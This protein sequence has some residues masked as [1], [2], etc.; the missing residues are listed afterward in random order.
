[1]LRNGRFFS[2]FILSFFVLLLVFNVFLTLLRHLQN[3][4]LYQSK[5]LFLPLK[6]LL[7]SFLF[8]QFTY[9]LLFF[10]SFLGRPS[11]FFFLLSS[12]LPFRCPYLSCQ[13]PLR[14]CHPS[15]LFSFFVSGWL[16]I[17]Y[18]LY[19]FSFPLSFASF[20]LLLKIS[21]RYY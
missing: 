18:L 21:F 6:A 15:F 4:P 20:L 19:L 12:W 14:T 13:P 8:A 7:S 17:S 1:M 5:L 10:S 11:F 2:T 9:F 3:T 16:H